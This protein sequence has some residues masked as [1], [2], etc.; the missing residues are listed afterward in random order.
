M[1]PNRGKIDIMYHDKDKDK[2]LCRLCVRPYKSLKMYESVQIS[3]KGQYYDGRIVRVRSNDKYNVR[4]D[5]KGLQK[6]VKGYLLRRSVN[7]L[8]EGTIVEAK[9]QG[10][11]GDW[12]KGK[13]K[14]VNADGTFDIRYED[15][16]N[17]FSVDPEHVR[18]I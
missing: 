2:G 4:T 3:V 18:L 13:I 14:K 15:G 8:E 6:N 12:F 7:T 11:S 1:N 17:E 10:G 16:D 9:F 5:L